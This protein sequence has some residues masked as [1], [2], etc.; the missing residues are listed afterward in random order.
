MDSKTDPPNDL[1]HAS[2]PDPPVAPKRP[3]LIASP[4]GERVDPFYWLRDDERRNSEV[5]AYLR[6]ENA[7]KE[8][9]LAAVKPLEDRLYTEIV[10]R[11]KQDD[12]TVPYHKHGYWYYTRF[13]PGKEHPIYAR[14][15]TSLD[16]PEEILLDANE[17]A[18]SGRGAPGPGEA[19]GYYQLGALEVSPNSA[20]LAFC[21]DTVGRREYELRFKNLASG[22]I[23]PDTVPGIEA[24]VAWANDNETVLY[25]EKDPQTLL[26][27][28]VKKH[29][30]RQDTK[31]DAL[32]MSQTDK[33]FYT[34]VAK[35]KSER[36][37]F[38]H[39]QSTVSSEWWYADADIPSL[40]FK[41]FLPHERDHEYQIDHLGDR[42]IIRTNWHA[43]NFRLMQ[44]P[45]GEAGDR[46]RWQDVVA[47]RDDAFIQDFEVFDS[48]IALTVRTGGL[49]KIS[50]QPL[51]HDAE[52][53]FIASDEP[54][55]TMAIS[56]N[57]ELSTNIVR[58]AYSSLTT[59]TTI[60]DYDVRNGEKTLLK[61]DPVM[62]SFDPADYQTEL[63][64]APSRD[65]KR[66]PVSIVYRKGFSR[67]GS[68][69]LLQYAYGAYGLSVDPM[70]SSARLS[71]L[72]R[73]FV[74]AIA[75]IRGGQEMGRA[76]YDD[77]RLLEKKHSFADFVDAT[78]ELLAKRYAA[79]GNIFAMGGSAG[80][81]TVAAVANTSG[82]DYRAI[83]AQVPFVDVVTTMLDESIPLT[84]N[85]YDEW[86]DPRE[87]IFYDYMLSY[88][89]Y[90]NVR[91]QPYPAM[92]VTTGLW[93]SQVQYYEPAKWVAKLRTLKTDHNP[94]LLHVDMEAGHGGKSGRYQR[95]REIAMEYAFVL[96][97]AGI[98]E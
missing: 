48:F 55:Y 94:L 92:L 72:D 70:F 30:L 60:Y 58:Y 77:G 75:H 46:N 95:Y 97:Q 50:V 22:E 88:S 1:I 91:A 13:E 42:F 3:H 67:D 40:P 45:L 29:R 16:A 8:R 80:G 62:G 24:D 14:R 39:M 98:T 56:I 76:W 27:L 18:A 79:K 69:P 38:I 65:G 93:D 41:V 74:Y 51:A 28:H 9:Q 21:E 87:R 12:S 43:R 44:T 19:E 10:A 83:V 81:L 34:G 71:L 89:P 78:Q 86:G 61:R 85:E 36:F 59:P 57:P 4:H 35:S 23:L 2:L 33:S 31:L 20:W 49:R 37:I 66:I 5:L 68:A 15:K 11:L 82:Q 7:Y 73:G 96:A 6:E 32:V 53:F 25:V 84:T 26:G 64:F 63:L 52:P 17:R 54:A 90:D 47:H